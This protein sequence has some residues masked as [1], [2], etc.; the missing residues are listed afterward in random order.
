MGRKRTNGNRLAVLVTA[1]LSLTL[2]AGLT[3]S[4]I[5][6][7]GDSATV[8]KKKKKK[9]PC[10]AGTH[11]VVIKKKKNGRII[12]KRKCVPNSTSSTPVTP[13]PTPTSAS[14][15]ISPTSFNFGNVNQG[16]LGNCQAPPDPDC[17]TTDFTVT[18]AGP[19]ASG[20]P[21]ASIAIV[22]TDGNNSVAFEVFA[23]TC[24]APLAPGGSCTV[25]VRA[26]DP[27]SN[28]F[29][30]RLDVSSSPGGTAS[31]TVMVQ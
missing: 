16:D 27:N 31:A 17:P 26:A 5:A 14:L 4:A 10:P 6:G 29:V 7:A 15:S 24:T 23:N 12:K 18:N 28:A 13:V 2:V 21:T 11:K 30:S 20:V 19:D 9:K 3:T 22:S 25:T 1:V 8:A